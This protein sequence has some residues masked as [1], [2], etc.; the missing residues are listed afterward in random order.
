MRL[1]GFPILTSLLQPPS[2][3]P[4]GSL[5]HQGAAGQHFS[6]PQD[7]AALDGIWQKLG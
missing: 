3:E 7:Y 1:P 2:Y 5:G 4:G 6:W